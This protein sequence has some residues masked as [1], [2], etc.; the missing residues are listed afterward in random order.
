[1]L[2]LGAGASAPLNLLATAPFLGFLTSRLQDF[3]EGEKGMRFEDPKFTQD[4]VQFYDLSA[5]HF[6]VDPPDSEVLLDYLVHLSET[7]DRL[8]ELP[9]VFRELAGTDGAKKF[10]LQWASMLRDLASHVR[11]VIV[12]HY[13]RVDGERAVEL[14]WPLLESLCE[15]GGLLPVFTTNYDWVFEHIAEADEDNVQVVDGFVRS[16]LG[17]K[18]ARKAFSDFRRET[19]KVN[20]VLFKVHGSTS[21]YREEGS[22]SVI[23]KFP[24][25][26]PELAG[27]RAVLIYPTQFKPE[28]IKEEPYHTAYEYLGETL[29]HTK[30]VVVV[31]F[32]FRDPA[33]VEVFRNVLAANSDLRLLVVEPRMNEVP[34]ISVDDLARDLGI[35]QVG[36]QKRMRV[37]KGLFGGALIISEVR[38]TVQMLD[39]WDQMEPLVGW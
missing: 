10:H 4:L 39:S 35:A 36:W 8:H 23:R 3:L 2:F 25:A 34:G 29:V 37:I 19:G 11:R 7:C 6:E 5:R 16:A 20:I 14:Y 24:V 32:S 28:A 38:R 31:G 22:P 27:T 15:K 17:E 21:W 1:V 18:W 13:S 12:E 30:L 33:I 26:R 9:S